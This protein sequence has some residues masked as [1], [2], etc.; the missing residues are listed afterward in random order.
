[1]C[2]SYYISL[3]LTIAFCKCSLLFFDNKVKNYSV[4]GSCM[5]T[6]SD[7][8]GWWAVD[9]LNPFYITKVKLYERNDAGAGRSY[10]I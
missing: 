6:A 1:M 3:V 5:H 2:A 4:Q 9:L 8:Y 7:H 10:Y